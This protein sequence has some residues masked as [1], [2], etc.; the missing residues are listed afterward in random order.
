MCEIEVKHFLHVD[1]QLIQ[2]HLL[3]EYS[4]PLNG[5]GTLVKSQLALDIWI[6][7]SLFLLLFLTRLKKNTG[8]WLLFF[9]SQWGNRSSEVTYINNKN[10]FYLLQA[11]CVLNHAGKDVHI[12][13]LNYTTIPQNHESLVEKRYHEVESYTLAC[14]I[15]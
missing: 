10:I 4:F 13:F 5:I 12:L 1:I 6:K 3:K 15:H 7:L 11:F 8:E 14:A 2:Y 9:F